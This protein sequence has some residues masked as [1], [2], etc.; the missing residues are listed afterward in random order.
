MVFEP[1]KVLSEFGLH[2]PANVTV[3]VHDSTADCRYLVLP[4]PPAFLTEAD[5]AR[6]TH[7]ELKALVSRDSMIGVAVL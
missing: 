5:I 7:G 3:K 2:V 6:M 4:M 1:R